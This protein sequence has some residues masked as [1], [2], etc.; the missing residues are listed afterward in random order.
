MISLLLAF[1]IVTT[2]TPDVE[3]LG[4]LLCGE[5]CGMPRAAMDLTAETLVFDYLERGI[6][7]LPTRWYAPPKQSE[8]ATEIV[9]KALKKPVLRQC[10]LIGNGND[11]LFWRAGGY[12]AVDAVPDYEWTVRDMTVAAFDCVE[13]KVRVKTWECEGEKCPR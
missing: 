2:V 5:T 7:W 3:Y 4:G 1:V 12:I 13:R 11:V 10:R 9:L 6:H 8:V